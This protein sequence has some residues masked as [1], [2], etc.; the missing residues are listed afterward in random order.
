MAYKLY[1]T[2]I[3]EEFKYIIGKFKQ[4]SFAKRVDSQYE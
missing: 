1:S 3:I 2:W 4:F